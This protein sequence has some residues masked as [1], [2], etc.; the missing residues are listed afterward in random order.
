MDIH[1]RSRAHDA[2]G[3]EETVYARIL[4]PLEAR[5]YEMYPE[6]EAGI[7]LKE[8]QGMIPSGIQDTIDEAMRKAEENPKKQIAEGEEDQPNNQKL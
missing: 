4:S 1:L 7:A 6:T 3:D 2:G 5:V 8:R